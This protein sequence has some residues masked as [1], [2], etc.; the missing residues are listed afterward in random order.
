MAVGE[1]ISHSRTKVGAELEIVATTGSGAEAALC[2]MQRSVNPVVKYTLPVGCRQLW[3]VKCQRPNIVDGV[4][5]AETTEM[6]TGF[7]RYIFTS[8][9]QSSVAMEIGKTIRVLDSTEFA[10]DRPSVAIGSVFGGTRIVQVLQNEAAV[11]DAGLFKKA[12][13]KFG[14]RVVNATI[15][16]S[17]MLVLLDDGSIKL[18][19]SDTA[20]DSFV[21]VELPAHVQS[22]RYLSAQLYRDKSKYLRRLKDA[23]QEDDRRS[24]K[25]RR[26]QK[27]KTFKSTPQRRTTV[28]I[29]DGQ[30]LEEDDEGLYG[31]EANGKEK[32]DDTEITEDPEALAESAGVET[33]GA[34]N[35]EQPE[36][37]AF[38]KLWSDDYIDL[39]WLNVYRRDGTLEIYSLPDMTPV[40][41]VPALH[42]L[43]NVLFD[44]P[45]AQIADASEQ[46]DR[47]MD[48]VEVVLASVGKKTSR[49]HLA[50]RCA[51]GDIVI[52][53]AFEYTTAKS[54]TE[55]TDQ[56][57]E[58]RLATRFRK[59]PHAVNFRRSIQSDQFDKPNLKRSA[60]EMDGTTNGKRNEGFRKH[61]RNFRKLLF[62]FNNIGGLSGLFVSGHM[63]SWITSSGRGMA[64]VHPMANDGVI[65]AFTAL[66]TTSYEE[67]FVYS[68]NKVGAG[69][70]KQSV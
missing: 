15:D 21:L 13:V 53:K 68:N 9:N 51:S 55:N 36:E 8:D 32:A 22:S 47:A 63:P 58:N 28:A 4:E 6:S 39:L 62:P 54:E 38:E 27:L 37:M 31:T 26:S 61:L 44:A 34:T 42:Q 29:D 41:S 56:A 3:A 67:A 59:V 1:P 64:R 33:N 65:N 18:Y 35:K 20:R 66:N 5:V 17:Y 7:D 40:F 16:D 30:A 14:G 69:Y 19:T 24:L 49:P 70:L 52:Y 57:N 50:L 11:Y 60:S 48:I 45:E 23:R 2:I 12:T 46:E 43:A 25:R 10:M